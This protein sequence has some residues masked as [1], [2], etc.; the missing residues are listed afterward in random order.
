MPVA[1]M[2]VADTGPLA[3]DVESAKDESVG[4]GQNP[5]ATKVPAFSSRK[6]LLHAEAMAA[7]GMRL[8]GSISV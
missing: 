4:R 6:A 5:Q 8:I 2:F 7:R 3:V 1:P